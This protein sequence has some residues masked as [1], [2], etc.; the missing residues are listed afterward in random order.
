M[1]IC[2]A[3][4]LTLS[5][6]KT[7][8]MCLRSKEMPE[9]N[10][11]VSVEVTGQAYNH[12]NEFV[13]LGRFINNKV[14]LSIEVDRRIRNAWCSFRKYTHE[15]YDRPSA[16]LEL[17][18]R[19][20]RA[21]VLKT[22]LYGCVTGSPRACHFHALR[23]AHHSFL[24]GCIV[25]RRSNNR[26]DLRGGPGK[27]VKGMFPGWPQSFWYQRRPVDDCNPGRGGMAERR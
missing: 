23:Q 24:T 12:T 2:A 6:A 16:P 21:E 22:T 18:I 8:T 11:I 25:G 7:E 26:A 17:Q 15:L 3:F 19:M 9:S 5:E 10:T 1:V 27:R 13:S 4:D 20:P 14:N